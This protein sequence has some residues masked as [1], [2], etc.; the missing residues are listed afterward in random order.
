MAQYTVGVD[1][2]GTKT[3]YAKLLFPH[4]TSPDQ[5]DLGLFQTYCLEPAMEMRGI[6][7]KQLHKMDGE[8]PSEMPAITCVQ[9][10]TQA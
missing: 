1:V 10:K 7:R 6:I 8:Y 3:A 4:V 9:R 2:G 5:A